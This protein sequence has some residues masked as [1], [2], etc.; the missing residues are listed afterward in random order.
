MTFN[1][2]VEDN[3]Q[4]LAEIYHLGAW[5]RFISY[6]AFKRAAYET[7]RS[8]IFIERKREERG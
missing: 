1:Q 7:A 3:K 4:P 6:E 5:N 2:Y 8:F